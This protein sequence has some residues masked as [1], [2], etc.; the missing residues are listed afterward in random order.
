MRGNNVALEHSGVVV[1]K[2][3]AKNGIDRRRG[4][5][6]SNFVS[7]NFGASNSGHNQKSAPDRKV[8]S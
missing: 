7:V 1:D 6:S 5:P 3:G 4:K 8:T 2:L